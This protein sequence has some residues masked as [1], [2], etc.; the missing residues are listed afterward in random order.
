[1][2]TK[3]EFEKLNYFLDACLGSVRCGVDFSEVESWFLSTIR[4]KCEELSSELVVL[5]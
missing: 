5:E 3:E 4:R 2:T 1:M